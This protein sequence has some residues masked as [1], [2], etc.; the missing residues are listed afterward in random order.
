MLLGSTWSTILEKIHH[1]KSEHRIKLREFTPSF[2]YVGQQWQK[3]F[4]ILFVIILLFLSLKIKTPGV[5]ALRP[6]HYTGIFL[7][8]LGIIFSTPTFLKAARQ[9]K[10]TRPGWVIIIWLGVIYGYIFFETLSMPVRAF[11]D[12]L[13]GSS[14]DIGWI[15]VLL[16]YCLHGHIIGKN[17]VR[18]IAWT[19][20]LFAVISACVAWLMYF[21]IIAMKV[22]GHDL[23]HNPAWGVRTH[24]W[25]GE[26][27]HLGTTAGV[28]ILMA[29]YL[30]GTV[31]NRFHERISLLASSVVLG[32]T[33]YGTGS[34]N[35]MLSAAIG[36]VLLFWFL[37][38]G[39]RQVMLGALGAVVG[40]VLLMSVMINSFT[41]NQNIAAA[42][43]ISEE[44]TVSSA[45]EHKGSSAAEHMLSSAAEHITYG[46]RLNDYEGATSRLGRFRNA[47]RVYMRADLREKLLGGGYGSFRMGHGSAMND[48]LE[49][50]LDFGAIF[51]VILLGYLSYLSIFFLRIIKNGNGARTQ[52]AIFGL[53]LLSFGV[54]FAFNMSSFFTCFFHLASFTHILACV[55]A[56]ELCVTARPMT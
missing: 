39:R 50:L 31:Q 51:V 8:F 44:N 15:M 46:F 13:I 30:L 56:I 54:V 36:V 47:Y 29:L 18:P 9:L 52:T 48:Y 12:F 2:G 45:A 19:L 41:P 11:K 34:R 35:G 10:L 22:M 14:V 38:S 26:P 42:V 5:E 33:I 4:G 24:G 55:F 20:L 1:N 16:G 23:V 17:S 43:K 3:V 27:T 25:F 21:N 7:L 32:A 40:G 28:G 37:K 53:I 6:L 49:S